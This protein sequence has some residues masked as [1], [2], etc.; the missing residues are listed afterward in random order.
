M[1]RDN[2]EQLDAVFHAL[3]DGKRRLILDELGKRDEQTLYEL[4]VRLID[5]HGLSITRQAISKHLKV[6]EEAEL[7]QTNWRGRT[8]LH[9]SNLPKALRPLSKWLKEHE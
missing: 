3:S 1:P 2:S 6:L 8:K 7:I 5:T 9:S 4:C